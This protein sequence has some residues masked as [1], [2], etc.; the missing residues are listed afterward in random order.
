MLEC[1]N[2]AKSQK[3]FYDYNNFIREQNNLNNLKLQRVSWSLKHEKLEKVYG[4][5]K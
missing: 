1:K 4:F 5:E 3:F 2:I